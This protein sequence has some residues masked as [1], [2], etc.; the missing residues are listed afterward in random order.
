MKTKIILIIFAISFGTA[1]YAMAQTGSLDQNGFLKG[2]EMY[3][4][5]LKRVSGEKYFTDT[6]ANKEVDPRMRFSIW[7]SDRKNVVMNFGTQSL[8]APNLTSKILVS[9][10]SFEIGFDYYQKLGNSDRYKFRGFLVHRSQHIFDLPKLGIRIPKSVNDDLNKN[11][12]HDLNILGVGIER[13]PLSG[14]KLQ[15]SY[16][17]Y[18]QPYNSDTLRLWKADE[19]NKYE[20]PVFVDGE[21]FLPL[22]FARNRLSIYGSGELGKS[23]SLG[24]LE[25]RLHPVKNLV[26]FAR[27]SFISGNHEAI[28]APHSGVVYRGFKIGLSIKI[29]NLFN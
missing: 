20:R 12:F 6:F 7:R 2:S 18:I 19:A 23:S 27:Q 11:V 22:S 26:V 13:S 28:V 1:S 14:D 4:S 24:T 5:F 21:I 10:V 16:R 25:T 3:L 29:G 9:L 17:A 8:I 15:Y